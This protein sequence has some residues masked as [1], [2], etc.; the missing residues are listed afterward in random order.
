[1]PCERR[2]VRAVDKP[3]TASL[4]TAYVATI[5][6]ALTQA[7]VQEAK[8]ATDRRVCDSPVTLGEG[9]R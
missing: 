7:G 6:A 5:R 4:T 8:D 9:G 2:A 3:S 1:M